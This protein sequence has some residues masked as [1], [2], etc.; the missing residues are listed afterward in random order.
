MCCSTGRFQRTNTSCYCQYWL[1]STIIHPPIQLPKEMHQRDPIICPISTT[2]VK[3]A[4]ELMLKFMWI[5]WNN[6]F[7]IKNNH[8][9]FQFHGHLGPWNWTHVSHVQM[10]LRT[11]ALGDLF[12]CTWIKIM[13]LRIVKF[14]VQKNR[15][16]K[17]YGQSKMASTEGA[18][19]PYWY[20]LK[21]YFYENYDKTKSCID[22]WKVIE[23]KDCIE[24]RSE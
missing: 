23:K 24:Y 15:A 10:C 4:M 22:R 6:L 7:S 18:D 11:G 1:S 17:Q 9:L 2:Q 16:L 3:K 5:I 20:C 19:C 21:Q 8:I 13:S 12:L 14:W